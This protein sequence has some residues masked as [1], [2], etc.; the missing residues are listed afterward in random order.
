LQET[1]KLGKLIEILKEW[2]DE[3]KG[4]VIIFVDRQVDA[5][6]LFKDLL[7][8]GYPSLLLHGGIDATDR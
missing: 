5:D 1:E 8:E 7:K 4:S 2:M 3:D 6:E